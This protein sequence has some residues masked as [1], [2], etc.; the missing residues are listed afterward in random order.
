MGPD[1]LLLQLGLLVAL[2]TARRGS[3]ARAAIAVVAA[4]LVLAL[5]CYTYIAARVLL[6]YPLGM[7][8]GR[9][10]VAVYA[11]AL[12]GV[13]PLWWIPYVQGQDIPILFA[14][15][16]TS[17]LWVSPE[18]GTVRSLNSLVD[19]RYGYSGAAS[20]PGAQTLPYT[21]QLLVA[22]G[23]VAGGWRW[24]PA[25]G[26]GLLPDAV[27]GGGKSHRQ[28]MAILPLAFLAGSAGRVIGPVVGA[29]AGVGLAIDG[30]TSWF[31][32]WV[33]DYRPNR[34]YPC[35]NEPKAV[36]CGGPP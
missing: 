11:I 25:V 20:W 36:W 10:L 12:A 24:L 16:R 7:V 28:M 6:A 5:S 1:V 3:G 33:P 35:A 34:M 31:H 26:L 19:R 2:D 30:V 9:R 13:T 32:Y 8:R 4:G 27:S 22:V 21:E 15:Q 17:A 23:A 29:I 18:Q 14:P